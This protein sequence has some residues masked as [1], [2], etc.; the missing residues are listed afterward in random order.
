[1]AGRDLRVTGEIELAQVPPLSPLAQ[2]IPD[3]LRNSLLD[4]RHIVG[5]TRHQ[6]PGRPLTEE[7]C[8]LIEHVPEQLIPQIADNALA[9]GAGVR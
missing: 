4:L 5:H 9:A 2:Q 7:L 8:R 3:R 6:M 1:M